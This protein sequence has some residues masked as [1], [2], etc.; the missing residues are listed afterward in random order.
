[1]SETWA[2]I[3]HSKGD[4]SLTTM[5]GGTTLALRHART[6]SKVGWAG[7]RFVLDNEHERSAIQALFAESPAPEG[8]GLE[9][10][11]SDS[12]A[13]HEREVQ[14]IGP[15]IYLRDTLSS[16]ASSTTP[17]PD[18]ALHEVA[19][20]KRAETFLFGQIRKSVELDGVIAFYVM[21]P[22]ARVFTRL[23]LNTSVSPNQATLAAL[24]CGIGAA[25]CAGIGGA[26][27]VALA[28]IL[29]WFGGVLDC[30]D[31]ELARMRLQSSKIGEWLDSM[32]DEFS[33]IALISGLGIGLARDGYG[34]Y[35]MVLGF[36]GAVVAVLTFI[37]MYTDLHRQK[38]PIDTAQFPWFFG[39]A[40]ASSTT[41]PVG[42]LG[43][44]INI[45]GYFIRRDANIT[46]TSLLLIFNLR[47]VSLSILLAAF[48]I[49]S[50]LVITHYTVMKIR[51]GQTDV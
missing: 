1:M 40:S 24:A 11:R 49:A 17:A 37:P 45:I 5:V 38:L 35:W 8:F 47:R 4:L 21:R 34:D 15:A 28:G 43:N 31:G 6:A 26:G 22:L 51:R 12:T 33:T 19:D 3:E 46:G 10:V 25:I 13:A 41:G 48:A 23:L 32:V 20:V 36:V 16:L 9:F 14:L 44:A 2:R 29:Y 42:F 7:L 27:L 39:S 50:I 30:I 18:F